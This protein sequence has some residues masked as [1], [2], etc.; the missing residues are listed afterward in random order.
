MPIKNIIDK[1]QNQLPNSDLLQTLQ[2]TL[3]QYFDSEGNF[4]LDK[5]ESELKES[6][7]AEARDGYRLSFVGK[8]Y[9]RLQTGQA[10]ET[11]IVPDS[12]HNNL[13]ENTNSENVFITGDNIE[14]LRHLQNSY[15]GRIKM[16]YIDPPYNT[17]KE[18]VYN[19]KFEFTDDK[20]KTALGYGD[21]EIERLKSIQ[22]KSSHSAWLTFMYPRIKLAQK[23]LTDDGVIFVSI[24]DNEQSN[25]KLLLDDIFGESN[26]VA[27]VIWNTGR[28]SMA[29]LIATNHE[30][31]LIYAKTKNK[32]S[33]DEIKS[34]EVEQ[35]ESLGKLW[36]EKKQGLEAIYKRYD[37]LKNEFGSKYDKISNGLKE[38]FDSLSDENPS[39]A[40]DHYKY[41]DERGIFF[42]DN[43]SQGTGD[44]G[45]FNILPIFQWNK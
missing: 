43:I 4:K 37:E 20:L 32:Q 31:C 18:F 25:L 9:A 29:K 41:A 14:V 36:R 35:E 7:I 27:S 26:F 30:Y 12:N 10:S 42:P 3:P 13:P 5:F 15:V 1:N 8:D 17:G 33:A 6:N 28:K 19:D 23:L 22:G 21:D 2:A 34:G 38:F 24:D 16:I 40:H 45:R 44:G 39:K 11:V